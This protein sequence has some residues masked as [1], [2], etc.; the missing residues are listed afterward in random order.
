MIKRNIEKEYLEKI[1]LIIRYNKNYYDLS[2]PLVSDDIY[3]KLKKE[4]FDL[5]KKYSFLKNKRSL[6]TEKIT[7]SIKEILNLIPGTKW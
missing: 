6:E 4:I 5:E 3:D 1:N 2:S 7:L